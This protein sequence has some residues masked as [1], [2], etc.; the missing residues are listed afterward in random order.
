MRIKEYI[1]RTKAYN[2][3]YRIRMRILP[4]KIAIRW[5]WIRFFLSLP[6]KHLR[7][8]LLNSF[9]NV[10]IHR[11]VPIYAGMQWWE[12]PFEVG[13]GTNIGFDCHIDC[14][15]GVYI[16]RNV[17]LATGVKIWTLHHDYNDSKFACVGAPVY[18][19][20]YCWICSYSIILPGVSIGEG[21]VV[22][23]GAVVT[24]DVEPWTVVGGVS[25]KVIGHREHKQY[26]YRPSNG[27]FPFV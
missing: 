4:W 21:A 27:W 22:A 7:L 3:Y 25:A 9:S 2:I 24:K 14:R 1:K 13:E 10:K 12:G 16:G 17:C 20:D 26:E 15:R 6:S 11:S 5:L 18:I 23:A 8:W 19:G